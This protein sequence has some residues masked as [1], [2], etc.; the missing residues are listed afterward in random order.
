MTSPAKRSADPEPSPGFTVQQTPADAGG[1]QGV[2]LWISTA[3]SRAA[4]PK[5]ASSIRRHGGCRGFT[6]P[7]P[8]TPLDERYEVVPTTL[9]DGGN[10][11]T[12]WADSFSKPR[13]PAPGRLDQMP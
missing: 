1:I 5:P 12:D 11:L 9:A 8:S 3:D 10:G 13:T 7:Y 2:A 6:G 4:G